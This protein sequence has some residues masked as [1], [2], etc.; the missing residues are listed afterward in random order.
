MT[1]ALSRGFAPRWPSAKTFRLRRAACRTHY[2]LRATC[3]GPTMASVIGLAP[4]RVCLKG[5]LLELLCIHGRNRSTGGPRTQSGCS[6]AD[7]NSADS[8]PPWRWAQANSEISACCWRPKWSPR[9]VARQR[10]LLFREALICLSYSGCL[11]T[12]TNGRP[13]TVMLRSL[14][15]ISRALC[16]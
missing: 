10:L 4:I 13:P 2:T 8:N 16:F 3:V 6:Q 15:V 12:A 14:P 9:L 5:R 11:R 7:I 1:L